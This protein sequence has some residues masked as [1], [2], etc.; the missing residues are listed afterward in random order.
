MGLLKIS[1]KEKAIIRKAINKRLEL[2]KSE[3]NNDFYIKY[4]V[5]LYDIRE[6]LHD[7]HI[8]IKPNIRSRL[9][10]CI[11]DLTNYKNNEIYGLSDFEKIKLI[12]SKYNEIA[13]IDTILILEEKLNRKRINQK[14]TYQSIFEKVD[15]LSKVDK[16]YYSHLD[17]GE[18]YK[19]A[20]VISG[21]KGMPIYDTS[22]K[23]INFEPISVDCYATSDE[24]EVV[25]QKLKRNL[26]KNSKDA[27]QQIL[28]DLLTTI[29]DLSFIVDQN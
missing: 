5:E 13:E 14:S 10:G 25:L 28:F 24:P 19:A 20:I 26:E 16:V 7:D 21:K 3:P 9:S 11:K 8:N 23:I 2:C 18:I 22:L 1:E 4:R 15:L 17:S 6:W 12:K 27:Y 29:K